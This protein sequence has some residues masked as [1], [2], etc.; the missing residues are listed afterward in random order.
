MPVIRELVNRISFKINP[1]DKAKAENAMKGI[2]SR[3]AGTIAFFKGLGGV[4]GAALKA[5]AA[6]TTVGTALFKSYQDNK[7]VVRF[8]AG[9]TEEALKFSK[10]L[11]TLSDSEIISKKEL[12]EAE[13]RFA[14]LTV[15]GDKIVKILPI[16]EDIT[17][18]KPKFDFPEVV[19]IA[20]SFIKEG[21]IDALEELG[22]IST[23]TAEK[24]R[25]SGLSFD[26]S[27]K[28]QENRFQFLAKNLD[29]NK[30]RLKELA[31]LAKKDLT[32]SF[33]RLTKEASDF[34]LKFG[35]TTAPVIK[36]IV[37]IA[38]DMIKELNE[39]D[40]FWK[41]VKSGAE[42][43]LEIIKEAIELAKILTGDDEDSEKIEIIDPISFKGAA[44]DARDIWNKGLFKGA[45]AAEKRREAF[46]EQQAEKARKGEASV[47]A[48]PPIELI[49]RA[50]T[51]TLPGQGKERIEFIKKKTEELDALSAATKRGIEPGTEQMKTEK[52]GL[53]KLGESASVDKRIPEV[54][55]SKE[56]PTK[57]KG[58]L[59]TAVDLFGDLFDDLFG[60]KKTT[61]EKESLNNIIKE[62][63]KTDVEKNTVIKKEQKAKEQPEVSGVI[64]PSPQQK[65]EISFTPLIIKGENIEGLDLAALSSELNKSVMNEVRDTFIS[66]AAQSG[67]LV[68]VSG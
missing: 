20:V 8:F 43:T 61:T 57:D 7:S 26:K 59:G 40:E 45:E 33:S 6:L 35:E 64:F 66:V 12:A 46:S 54:R 32:F 19:D 24:Y 62:T 29:E 58:F 44:M 2:E 63:T 25:L 49:T 36:E 18:A 17:I 28:G 14:R 31:E 68:G 53:I 65:I 11:D 51:G 56:I 34:A 10:A 4:I 23:K 30:E 47:F 1:G 15:S 38:R 16:L 41:S 5:I 21:S 27:I 55:K 3:G 50:L 22:A 13:A 67:R 42:S 39:S 60:D 48:L 52:T 9:S 37:T